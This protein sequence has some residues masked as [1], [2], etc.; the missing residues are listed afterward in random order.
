MQTCCATLD[1]HWMTARSTDRWEGSRNRLVGDGVQA[2]ATGTEPNIALSTTEDNYQH[3]RSFRLP[4]NITCHRTG[5]SYSGT[6]VFP[7]APLS[8]HRNNRNN[9]MKSRTDIRM[10]KDT[11]GQECSVGALLDLR[12][13]APG[14]KAPMFAGGCSGVAVALHLVTLDREQ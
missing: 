11:V 9:S 7:K 13:T 14:L 12:T 8:A 6:S 2:I 3:I 10:L 4:F 1:T 5:G